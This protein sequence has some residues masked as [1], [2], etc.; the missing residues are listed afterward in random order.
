MLDSNYDDLDSISQSSLRARFVSRHTGKES[1]DEVENWYNHLGRDG[2]EDIDDN[3]SQ[4]FSHEQSYQHHVLHQYVHGLS[5]RGWGSKESKATESKEI[6]AKNWWDENPDKRSKIPNSS[7]YSHKSFDELPQN[8]QTWI[9]L[10]YDTIWGDQLRAKNLVIRESITQYKTYINKQ[11]NILKKHASVGEAVGL[12]YGL[13]SVDGK[14][15]K[16]T[17]AYAGVSLNDRIY[18][19]EELA[20]GH[21]KHLPLL[22]NHSSIVGAENELDRLSSD[23][24]DH[25][26][27][28]EDYKV[29]NVTLTW[30]PKKLT[31]FYEGVI[32]DKFFQKE[33]DDM[34]M[35]VSLGIYYDSNSP[36]ICDESCYTVIKGAEFREVS[37]VYHAGFPIATI[38][39]VESELRYRSHE[40]HTN[41]D[42][43][44]EELDVLP[45]GQTIDVEEKPVG[46][47]LTVDINE[48]TPIVAESLK[49]AHNFSVRGVTGMTISNSNGVEK[50]RLDPNMSY[51]TNM[52]HF[53]V[54]AKGAQI[55]GEQLQP[56]MTTP[57]ELTKEI[58]SKPN[59]IFTRSDK[60]IIKK[61]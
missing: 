8:L 50:Y 18:L 14:K 40:N 7:T 3:V 36:Q 42:L 4:G 59:I 28:E 16:G 41:E 51:E 54:S 35:A 57:K 45:I 13:P 17:L 55:F 33:V 39:A 58:E 43:A 26:N 21:G 23:I 6:F 49:T 53:D 2:K 48:D 20:K 25:L 15:I 1:T 44:E 24:I 29:G 27:N 11:I 52:I 5:K 56:V 10:H 47:P 34:N 32:E 9:V 19:P 38:E 37:L 12:M 22:L 60:D 30:D 31:L 46:E 61:N